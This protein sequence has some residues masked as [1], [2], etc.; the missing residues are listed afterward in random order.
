VE[1]IISQDGLILGKMGH[2]ERTGENVL[3]NIYG[4]KV[5]NIFENAIN[6]F[7]GESK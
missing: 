2:S 6:Y 4:N 1:G 7:R 3:K 5:Q